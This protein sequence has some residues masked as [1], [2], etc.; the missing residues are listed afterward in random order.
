MSINRSISILLLAGGKGERMKTT[1]PKQF[2]LI[3]GKPVARY[4]FDVFTTLPQLA[5]II[6]ICDPKFRHFF[7]QGSSKLLI[8]FAEPG[9][10]RQDSVYNGLKAM[11]QPCEFIGIHDAARPLINLKLCQRVLKAAQ[12][13]GAAAPGLPAKQTIKEVDSSGLVIKTLQRAH[14]WEIQT[15]QFMELTSFQKAF[16]YVLQNQLEV[17]DDVS[18][19]ELSKLPVKIEEGDP[20]NIKI[21]TPEDFAIVKHWISQMEREEA[22]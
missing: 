13:T 17:T 6:V 19:M 21:T 2:L 5:E 14:L 20:H 18:I 1:T 11:T 9:K 7:Q 12:E 22:S 15:P 10:R 3:E 16:E 4:S 8:T